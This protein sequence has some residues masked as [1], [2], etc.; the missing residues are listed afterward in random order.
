MKT[1]V[2]TGTI[3][4]IN[5]NPLRLDLRDSHV[6]RA[7][8]LGVKIAINTDAHRPEHFAFR[9]FGVAVGQ[10]GWLP[11]EQVV[12]TWS[13]EQFLAYLNKENSR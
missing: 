7:V 12:N 6:R 8:E 3:L 10:R 4:E 1:A 9:H 13:L 5:A 2:S 11:K